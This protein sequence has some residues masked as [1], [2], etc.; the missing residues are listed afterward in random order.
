MNPYVI[1]G[2]VVTAVLIAGGSAIM[3][4]RYAQGQAAREEVLIQKAGDASAERAAAAI[5]GLQP[6]YTTINR[7]LETEIRNL[8]PT[9]EACNITRAALEAINEARKAP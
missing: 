5:A 8:P 9:P 1:L 7:T 4:Y 3:G 6:K 2:A